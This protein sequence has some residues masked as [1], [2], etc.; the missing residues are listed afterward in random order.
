MRP[1]DYAYVE[2]GSMLG[3]S[4]RNIGKSNLLGSLIESQRSGFSNVMVQD[5]V[6]A[7]Q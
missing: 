4:K 2:T 7:M 5:V 1:E 6:P 3:H